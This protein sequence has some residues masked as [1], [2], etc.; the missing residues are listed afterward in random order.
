MFCFAIVNEKGILEHCAF[1]GG[2]YDGNREREEMSNGVMPIMIDPMPENWYYTIIEE[3]DL[4]DIFADKAIE[5]YP[6]DREIIRQMLRDND[7]KYFDAAIIREDVKVEK[8]T[9]QQ[10]RGIKENPENPEVAK[11]FKTR[12]KA[13]KIKAKINEVTGVII[14]DIE[15]YDKYVK[16]DKEKAKKAQEDLEEK[17]RMNS[18]EYLEFLK[19]QIRGEVK[20]EIRAEIAQELK[21]EI[22]LQLRKE[23]SSHSTNLS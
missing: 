23:L 19:Q 13:R 4:I 11:I 3:E 5:R 18:K 16:E 2:T 7:G 14:E 17:E 12:P 8:T 15:N 10:I 21:G 6:N 9:I 1:G 22:L 20:E